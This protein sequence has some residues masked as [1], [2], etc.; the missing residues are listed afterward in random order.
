MVRLITCC[1]MYASVLVAVLSHGGGKGGGGDDVR[2]DPPGTVTVYS[3]IMLSI[4][5]KLNGRM[6]NE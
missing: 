6:D 3:L 2:S 4:T 5:L 1:S